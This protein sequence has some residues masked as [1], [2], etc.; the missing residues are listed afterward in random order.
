MPGGAWLFY[1]S[2]WGRTNRQIAESSG[3][4]KRFAAVALVSGRYCARARVCVGRQHIP[5]STRACDIGERRESE[6]SVI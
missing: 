4:L 2:R 6:R 1:T 5:G 3:P